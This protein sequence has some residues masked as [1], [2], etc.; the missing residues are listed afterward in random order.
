ML[1][2]ARCKSM[3]KKVVFA[4]NNSDTKITVLITNEI[5]SEI[6]KK[7]PPIVG[8]LFEI[9]LLFRLVGTRTEALDDLLN[10]LSSYTRAISRRLGPCTHTRGTRARAGNES[11]NNF[12]TLF[13]ITLTISLP[14]HQQSGTFYSCQSHAML[15]RMKAHSPR[16]RSHDTDMVSADWY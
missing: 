5:D 14:D 6:D 1:P 12:I 3:Q 9:L 4:S 15:R 16:Y 7:S 8:G 10:V 13:Q 11:L 2:H